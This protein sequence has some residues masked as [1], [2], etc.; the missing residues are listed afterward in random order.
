MNEVNFGN[1]NWIAVAVATVATFMLGGLWYSAIFGKTWVKCQGWSEETVKKMQAQMNPAKFFGGMLVSYFVLAIVLA[2]M[3]QALDIHWAAKGAI[4]GL[5]LWLAVAA[6]KMTDH[7]AS[8]KP[9]GLYLI[10][11]SFQLIYL[12]GMGALLAGWR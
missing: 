1:V 6:V 10:D 5:G 4:V 8:G 7:I 11:A 12:V 2:L 9:T 3:V